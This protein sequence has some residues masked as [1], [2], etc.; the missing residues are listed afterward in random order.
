MNDYD[1]DLIF[2]TKFDQNPKIKEL[3]NFYVES[4]SKFPKKKLTGYNSGF[5]R[6]NR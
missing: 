4:F 3:R 2:Q 5:C 1:D 6:I